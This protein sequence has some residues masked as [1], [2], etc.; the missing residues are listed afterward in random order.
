MKKGF[1]LIEV[2]VTVAILMM[3]VAPMMYSFVV[4]KQIT[5]EATHKINATQIINLWFEGVQ[6]RL[7]LADVEEL[8][9]SA[10][11]SAEG[12]APIAEQRLIRKRIMHNYWLEFDLSTVVTPDPASDL[13]VVVARVSWDEVYVPDDSDRSL[14]M[15]MFTNEPL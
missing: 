14:Y 13:V 7:N 10:E 6:R 11:V 15:V 2:I 12:F 9:G 3:G 8:I 1:T 5:N 4:C